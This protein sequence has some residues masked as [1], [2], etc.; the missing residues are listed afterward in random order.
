MI[1]TVCISFAAAA[2]RSNW[3]VPDFASIQYAPGI[4][5]FSAGA[6]YQVFNNK[7][8]FS[9]HFGIAPVHKGGQLKIVSMKFFYKPVTL[10]VWNR[11]RMNPIDIGV[12]ASYHNGNKFDIQ[13]QE[14]VYPKGYYWWNPRLRAHLAIENSVTYEF[15]KGHK[16][17][18]A[19]GFIEFNTNELHFVNFIRNMETV[20]L[21][22]IVKIGTGVRLTF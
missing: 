1:S 10:T 18:S 3:A 21:W 13:R 19:T 17:T 5:Y 6:G 14:G 22:D 9:T 2:Q 16:F 7:A 11:V 15:K 20:R 4:G 8:R 12:M